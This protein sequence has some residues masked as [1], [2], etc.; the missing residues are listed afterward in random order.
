MCVSIYFKIMKLQLVW[1]FF[2]YKIPAEED[3]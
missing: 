1:V 3:K 2:F